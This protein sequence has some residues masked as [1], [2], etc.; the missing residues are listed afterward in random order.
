MYRVEQDPNVSQTSCGMSC[1]QNL[2]Q[3]GSTWVYSVLSERSWRAFVSG[4][5]E[6]HRQ[7]QPRRIMSERKQSTLASTTL[8]QTYP[9]LFRI[10]TLVVRRHR[11]CSRY[12]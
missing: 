1:T 10:P 2:W 9:S 12:S 7:V 4:A 8:N 3:W 6:H 11:P 5:S